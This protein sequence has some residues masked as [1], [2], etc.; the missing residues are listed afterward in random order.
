[1]IRFW[2]KKNKEENICYKD[3]IF[4]SWVT[5]LQSIWNGGSQVTAGK[6]EVQYKAGGRED[7]ERGG[8]KDV[9][10]QV[11]GKIN[12]GATSWDHWS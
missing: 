8:M 4:F 6:R 9:V 5:S 7:K 12:P 1:M 11:A 3:K 2:L 10:C